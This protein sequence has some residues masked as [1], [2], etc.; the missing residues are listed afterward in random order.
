MIAGWFV[1]RRP[2]GETPL[3]LG[4]TGKQVVNVPPIEPEALADF[5][6]PEA[7]ADSTEPEALADPVAESASA[8]GSRTLSLVALFF[9]PTVLRAS[10]LTHLCHSSAKNRVACG[11]SIKRYGLYRLSVGL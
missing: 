8:S 4:H 6:E 1:F 5:T 11:F 10:A 7:L 3:V 9:R 2:G